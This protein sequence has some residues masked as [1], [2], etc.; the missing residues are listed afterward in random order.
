MHLDLKICI[1][2]GWEKHDLTGGYEK[3]WVIY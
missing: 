1:K 2:P 3:F